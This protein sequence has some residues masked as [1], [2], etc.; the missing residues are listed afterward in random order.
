[1]KDGG[2][3]CWGANYRGELGNNSTTAS[4]V[5]VGVSGLSSGVT[6]ITAS[7]DW[8]DTCAIQNGGAWCWGAN[9]A[10]QLGNGSFLGPDNCGF[11][12]CSQTPVA[13][14]NLTTGVSAISAGAN[15][16][17]ALKSGAA[18]CWGNNNGGQLGNNSTTNSSVPVPVSGMGGP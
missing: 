5:S 10:G 13:V 14:S 11:D 18:L 12:Y 9:T 7:A 3:W 1:L 17:C 4:A 16:T 8:F 15:F 6:T 2:A